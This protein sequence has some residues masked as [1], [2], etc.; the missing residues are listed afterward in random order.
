MAAA[1][2]RR[3]GSITMVAS[4]PHFS[5][6]CRAKKWNCPPVITIG[7]AKAERSATRCK[8]C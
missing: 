1:E 6:W 5:A 4:S 2:S 8:A 7:A 3:I